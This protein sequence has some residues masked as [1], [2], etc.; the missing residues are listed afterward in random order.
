V[1]LKRAHAREKVRHHQSKILEYSDS[2]MMRGHAEMGGAST[3]PPPA[4]HRALSTSKI[5][6]PKSKTYFRKILHTEI[7]RPI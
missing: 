1:T 6:T 7:P 3:V 5:P 4:A 2:M